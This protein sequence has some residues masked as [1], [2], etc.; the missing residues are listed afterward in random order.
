M[1]I[2][3]DTW[4]DVS[5][6]DWVLVGV[7]DRLKELYGDNALITPEDWSEIRRRHD[8]ELL[9]LYVNPD[10]ATVLGVAQATYA[11]RPPY[12]KV[13]VNSVVVH[14][15]VR[16]QSTGSVLMQELHRQCLHRWSRT[17]LFQLTSS[18]TRGTRS[19][20]ERLGYLARV[21]H[22]SGGT[23]AYEKRVL[24]AHL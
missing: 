10:T 9:L 12:P 5:Q 22:E 11:F 16:G 14:A 3:A 19:F 21:S 15:S 24:T 23:I 4:T 13:Y 7:N 20:Y 6:D 8:S 1:F 17:L 18:P 2:V